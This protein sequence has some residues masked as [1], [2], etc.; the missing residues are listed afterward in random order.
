LLAERSDRCFESQ[1]FSFALMLQKQ[2]LVY[3]EVAE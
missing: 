1:G 3:C 2:F